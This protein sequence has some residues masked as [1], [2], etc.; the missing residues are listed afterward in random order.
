[1]NDGRRVS[2]SLGEFIDQFHFID[3]RSSRREAPSSEFLAGAVS[4]CRLLG[5]FRIV[6]AGLYSVGT[7]RHRRNT[8]RHGES[9]AP[10]GS[11]AVRQFAPFPLL[12][13]PNLFYSIEYDSVS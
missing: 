10:F 12:R 13:R 5:Y 6:V 1:M 7:D 11:R 2:S 3:H 8:D 9:L 4:H